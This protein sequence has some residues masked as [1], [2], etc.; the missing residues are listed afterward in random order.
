M[1]RTKATTESEQLESGLLHFLS[2]GCHEGSGPD[3]NPLRIWHVSAARATLRRLWSEHYGEIKRA[4]PK[5]K[6]PWIVRKLAILAGAD[7]LEDSGGFVECALHDAA[8]T[9]R[10]ATTDGDEEE[11]REPWQR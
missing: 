7:P 9:T 2:V 10:P 5:G 6:R 4:T 8:V 1:P 3:E 11:E